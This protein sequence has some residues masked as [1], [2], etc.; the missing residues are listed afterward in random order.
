VVLFPEIFLPITVIGLRF[1]VIA[2][3]KLSQ[4]GTVYCAAYLP[5]T[6]P[7]S[8]YFVEQDGYS[9][10]VLDSAQSV[11]VTILD[12]MPNTE[13]DVYCYTKDFTLHEMT[14]NATLATKSS[15]ATTCC[16]SVTF[17]IFFSSLVYMPDTT[18]TSSFVYEL[19][20]D[21]VPTGNAT[22]QISVEAAPSCVL[23]LD[24]PSKAAAYPS[25][26]AFAANDTSFNA[27]F[28]ITGLPGCYIVN[29][30][31]TSS[32]AAQ[33]YIPAVGEVIIRN[34]SE[35]PR[36][37][38]AAFTDDGRK[39][40]VTFDTKTDQGASIVPNY[41]SRF[42]CA[43]VL[44]FLGAWNATC[45]W[46]STRI[47]VVDSAREVVVGD[48]LTLLSG[49]LM[50][51]CTSASENCPYANESS[52][53]I[54]APGN[55]VKP[56]ISLSASK[57][58]GPCEDIVID[59]T[60]NKG[61]GGRAWASVV[62]S[63][64]IN[65]MGNSSN[66]TAFLM[67]TFPTAQELVVIP[68]RLLQQATF[69]VS[70][71]LT[72]FLGQ[73]SK[74]SISIDVLSLETVPQLSIAGPSFQTQFRHQPTS[75][76]AIA[77]MPTC[78]GQP[79]ESLDY[80]WTLYEDI[81]ALNF[82]TTSLDARYFTLPE[83][84]L[85]TGRS[86]TAQII[87]VYTLPD[88]T[89]TSEATASVNLQILRSD[90]FTAIFGGS[91]RVVSTSSEVV[92]DASGSFDKDEPEALLIYT[93]ACMQLV[94]VYG[95]GCPFDTPSDSNFTIPANTVTMSGEV[96]ELTVNVIRDDTVGTATQV[97]T[98]ETVSLPSFTLAGLQERYSPDMKI[99]LTASIAAEMG[100]GDVI[101][102][103]VEVDS[104][105]VVLASIA[106]T[107]LTKRFNESQTGVYQ[108]SIPPHTL[109]AGITY[110]FQLSVAYASSPDDTSI[111]IVDISINAP[112]TDG[113]L[114]VT[115][116]IGVALNTTFLFQA[117]GYVDRVEDYPILYVLAYFTVSIDE[118]I[119]VKNSDITIY[120]YA[121]VGQGLQ[122][123][124]YSVTCVAYVRD[125]FGSEAQ[126]F[127]SIT[128][129]PS[130]LSQVQV[131]SE[132][133]AL[134]E[135]AFLTNDVSVVSQVVGALTTV[136]NEVNCTVP[137]ACD[138]LNREGCSEV[139]NTCGKCL[140]GFFGSTGTRPGN[141]LCFGNPENSTIEFGLIGENCTTNDDCLSGRC[142]G[143][144]CIDGMKK[145]PNNCTSVDHGT[146]MFLASNEPV[147]T[148]LLSDTFCNPVCVCENGWNGKDCSLTI[149]EFELLSSARS[150]LCSSLLMTTASQDITSDVITSRSNAI[151]GI[152]AD[153]T[154]LSDE[155]LVNC[156]ES[157][158]GTIDADPNLAG[159]SANIFEGVVIALSHI[160]EK[161]SVDGSESFPE[162][163]REAIYDAISSLSIGIQDNKAINEVK[164]SVVTSNIRLSTSLSG[165]LAAST[166]LEA[167]QTGYE[168]YADVTPASLTVGFTTIEDANSVG[169]SVLQYTNNP[170]GVS[171]DAPPLG[172]EVTGYFNDGAGGRRLAEVQTE[173]TITLVNSISLTN[174]FDRNIDGNKSVVCEY[175]LDPYIVLLDCPFDQNL[176]HE[177]NGFGGTYNYV[178]PKREYLEAPQCITYNGTGFSVDPSC[179][180]ISFDSNTTTCLCTDITVSSTRRRLS[181]AS[182]GLRDFTAKA[183]I[184]VSNFINNFASLQDLSF[185]D[186][187]AN[188]VIV[189][190]MSSILLVTFFGLFNL[191]RIDREEY[192]KRDEE[193][194][195]VK[196]KS[197]KAFM[198][199]A[200]PVE[201]SGHA[202]Y[203][204]FWRKMT[205]DHDWLSIFMPFTTDGEYR[206][207]RWLKAMGKVMNFLFI[208]TILAFL[209][210]Q[211]DGTCEGFANESDCTRTSSV[212]AIDDLCMWDPLFKECSFNEAIGETFLSA[213]I[214]TT[215]ITTVAMPLDAL[216]GYAVNQIKLY[217]QKDPQDERGVILNVDETLHDLH[218][219]QS[220]STTLL[221]AAR[222][223]KMQRLMDEVPVQTEAANVVDRIHSRG[224][225]DVVN[226]AANREILK[227]DFCTKI[228]NSSLCRKSNEENSE[229]AKKLRNIERKLQ[230]ARKDT[231]NLCREVEKL[232]NNDMREEFLL[233]AF[234]LGKLSPLERNITRQFMQLDAPPL[235]RYTA[236][237]RHWQLAC[238][239]MVVLYTLLV[240]L[241]VILFGF[242]IGQRATTY[243]LLGAGIALAQEIF[244]LNPFRIWVKSI[245]LASYGEEKVRL[246]HGLLRERA[247]A[248]MRRHATLMSE[249]N[250]YIQHF[251]PA[252]RASRR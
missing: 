29:A 235:D 250:A 57:T 3:I 35:P 127:T 47:L 45:R 131:I 46:I 88:G 66:I 114:Q 101:A 165:S 216:F 188:Y 111:A 217:F 154:Q 15:V 32:D 177:C 126:A 205:Y 244:V 171:A 168:F 135:N 145:C 37:L 71:Q 14:L 80:R 150:L 123:S 176:T 102:Q 236:K 148:C 74:A 143:G 12:L 91:E 180:V 128:V 75:L 172:L 121:V 97:L 228:K 24:G 239:V 140:P 55:A 109:D 125:Y 204:K 247:A 214:L 72:N 67:E 13:Y 132:A 242:Q 100:T 87:V 229:E 84:S 4:P 26:L 64:Q 115:P 31:V 211:D 85:T 79:T 163:L 25:S 59:P 160:L 94:P 147:D 16:S 60:L 178:C 251:N 233:R 198:N 223:V 139:A 213:L 243:W 44:E 51:L 206:S 221:R 202:W 21:T 122:N 39:V 157:L 48:T 194:N 182:S 164:D 68:N 90:I 52:V 192:V 138:T 34:V 156:T 110:Q 159:S 117:N 212:N 38:S 207:V 27:N 189:S 62:W 98:F 11:N 99:I 218:R 92:M 201:Y 76:Y 33:I 7:A 210:F 184:V 86:Y 224:F 195:K 209:Y 248:I 227:D 73:L 28:I 108:L 170:R 78:G 50:P 190:V 129:M 246:N 200:L 2:N 65:G 175:A 240:T 146:C 137:T 56:S 95:A 107:P 151:S 113:D 96:Y 241:Y 141:S 6:A 42:A 197:A 136:I 187:A 174:Y 36:L 134:I 234:Y 103:W 5:G 130:N 191:T 49:V 183:K 185:D 119:V 152:F 19:A 20:L 41:A 222:L 105:Q 23:N 9:E 249:A 61:S 69:T 231:D 149:A 173:V 10:V 63:V 203:W 18:M 179:S 53:T 193:K 238:L 186:I 237:Q 17:P 112:P 118:Q 208:D 167:P 22:V 83:N 219:H 93:W 58:V 30:S 153:V 104:A 230:R 181:S 225:D 232:D 81:D 43:D 89:G 215:I 1:S 161:I 199:S 158:L 120:K 54:S 166:T 8:Q 40:I 226:I 70:L 162:S 82:T 144:I 245:V 169:V 133:E 252:C 196:I 77:F 116:S 142:A 124:N 106:M 220:F 155:A